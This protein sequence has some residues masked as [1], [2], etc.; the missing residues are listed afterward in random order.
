MVDVLH[1]VGHHA[2]SLRCEAAHDRSLLGHVAVDP[3]VGTPSCMAAF[4]GEGWRRSTGD[5]Q[6]SRT[7]P[8]QKKTDSHDAASSP[9]W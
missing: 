1:N 4:V 9:P 3:E 6:R 5:D 8:G 7:G 2:R